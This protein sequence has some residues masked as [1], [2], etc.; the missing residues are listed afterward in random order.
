MSQ[1]ELFFL[2]RK[3]LFEFISSVLDFH[4]WFVASCRSQRVVVVV[5]IVYDY[6][7]AWVF[8]F[9]QTK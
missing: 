5:F 1:P 6:I 8:I 2:S 4:S 3:F 9:R 7:Y